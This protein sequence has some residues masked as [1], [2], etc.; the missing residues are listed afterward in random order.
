MKIPILYLLATLALSSVTASAL[1]DVTILPSR[2]K[3]DEDKSRTSSSSS[4]VTKAITYSVKVTNRA[5]R[6][7]QNV[8][9]KYN[10][11]YED[12]EMGSKMEGDV[13]A[14]SGSETI[15]NIPSNKTAEFETKPIK[16]KKE[17]LDSGWS[18]RD[19]GKSSA[20][21]KVVG[22]WFKAF[23]AEGQQVG[24]Y[25]NPTTV[26]KKMTWKE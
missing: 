16:L 1:D 3:L 2:R 4:E 8:T 11:F 14:V 18:F 19:G 25:A 20:R 22:V 12:M 6:E 24:E 26:P 23:N 21:D 9:V 17:S 5:F 10:I 15:P 7:L 13:K